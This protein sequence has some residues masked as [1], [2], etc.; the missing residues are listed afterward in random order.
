MMPQ[1]DLSGGSRSRRRAVATADLLG[2]PSRTDR[3]DAVGVRK[4]GPSG[5]W[6]CRSPADWMGPVDGWHIEAVEQEGPVSIRR[7][8]GA[9]STDGDRPHERADP[10]D[11]MERL[12]CRPVS[13]A[14]GTRFR[15]TD[16][17]S[18]YR[19]GGMEA[20]RYRPKGHYTGDQN[21]LDD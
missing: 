1:R 3:G 16:F 13:G 17:G 19:P 6:A 5:W 12:H 15:V 14:E 7:V 4:A 21:R 18:R 2:C 11:R 20:D 8:H 10:A 9:G